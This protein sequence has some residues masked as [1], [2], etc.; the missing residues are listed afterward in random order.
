MK[1]MVSRSEL[2]TASGLR[3][4]LTC[5]L[6]VSPEEAELIRRYA[7]SYRFGKAGDVWDIMAHP[8]TF[9]EHDVRDMRAREDKL[10]KAC[11]KLRDRLEQARHYTGQED[12]EF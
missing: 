4:V 1:L 6:E 2:D 11:Q 9:T 7:P 10:K 12:F 8:V 3:F 5:K